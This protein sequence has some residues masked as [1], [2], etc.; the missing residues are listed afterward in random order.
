MADIASQSSLPDDVVN[1]IRLEEELRGK[2]RS[3]LEEQER[4]QNDGHGLRGFLNTKLGILVLSTI[5]VPAFGGLY[6]HMQQRAVQRN[7]EN[8][9]T[10]KLMAEF[11]WRIS[12]IEY[13]RSH[14]PNEPDPDKWAS[15]AWIWRA[16]V[17]DPGYLPTLPEF[18]RVHLG[19]IVA[20]FRALGYK[21][22]GDLVL[23]TVKQMESG[24][25]AVPLPGQPPNQDHTYDVNKLD[26][27]LAILKQFRSH[28]APKS[29]FWGLLF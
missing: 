16:I 17:G 29:G 12:E 11:D 15:A 21:D 1:R 28:I 18:Q 27:Q 10:I 6:T 22:P 8:Q 13:H 7:T 24:G 14:I 23:K 26:S 5:L 20:Q 19:G 2:V 9:Q 3:E 25:A 4:K